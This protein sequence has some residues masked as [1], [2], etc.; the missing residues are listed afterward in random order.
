MKLMKFKVKA[1][2][3]PGKQLTI[4]DTLSR[5]PLLH[6]GTPNTREEVQS[7]EDW[8]NMYLG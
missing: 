4:A 2:Y 1:K 5:S 6:D 8:F 7:V 3:V